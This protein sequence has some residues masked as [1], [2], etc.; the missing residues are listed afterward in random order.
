MGRYRKFES[1]IGSLFRKNLNLNFE[2]VDRDINAQKKRVDDLIKGNPQPSEVVDARLGFP[3]LRE[4]L[5]DTDSRLAQK[6]QQTELEIEKARINNLVAHAGNTGGNAELLDIRV[7]IDGI[8]HSTAGGAVR[9]VGARFNQLDKGL[10]NYKK[11]NVK[12]KTATFSSNRAQ[13]STFTG[14]AWPLFKEDFSGDIFGFKIYVCIG[15][16]VNVPAK[17]AILNTSRAVLQEFNVTIPATGWVQLNGL[18]RLADLPDT[19]FIGITT[20]NGVVLV[21]PNINTITEYNDRGVI[22]WY[23]TNGGNTWVNASSLTSYRS[24]IEV[25][26]APTYDFSLGIEI[27]ELKDLTSDN[28][29]SVLNVDYSPQSYGPELV[30]NPGF[31]SWGASI[32]SWLASAGA[33]TITKETVAPYAGTNAVV[34]THGNNTLWYDTQI[35][36]DI[37]V[38]PGTTYELTFWTK[39][40]GVN[41]GV[42]ALYRNTAPATYLI[43]NGSTGVTGVNW[44][45]VT[46]QFTVPAGC[47]SVKIWFFAPNVNGGFAVFDDVSFKSLQ[48]NNMN[49][50][51]TTLQFILDNFPAKAVKYDNQGTTLEAKNIQDVI[52]ELLELANGTKKSKVALNLPEKYELVVGDTFELFYKGI[53]YA[54]NPYIY[55][56]KVTS[57]KGQAFSKR[58][59]YT[60]VA[61]DV[62]T[63]TLNIS[64][65]DDNDLVLD[66][67]S[68]QLIVKPKATSPST[69]KVV[70]C[71]G[72]SLTTGGI[73]PSE[74]YRRL[75]GTSGNP[76]GDGIANLKTIGT[77]T[78]SN[79]AKYEGYGG[80]TFNQYNTNF[81]STSGAVWVS[82]SSGMKTE[83][84]YQHSVWKDSNGI[85]WKIETIDAE[86]NRLKM[87]KVVSGNQVIPTSGTL[88][89]VSGGGDDTTAIVYT[90]HSYETSNPFW[91]DGKV[92]FAA[93][94]AKHGVARIDYV[95][96]LL[97]WNSTTNTEEAY[98]NAARTFI[99]NVRASFPNAEIIFMGLQV[100]SIDGF[101][102]NYGAS[103]N[104]MEKLRAVFNFDKWYTDLTK[105]YEKMD[106]INIAGQFDTEHNHPT[107]TRAV[108]VRNSLI[109]TYGTNGV[110]PTGEGYRQIADAVYR[111]LTHKITSQ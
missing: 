85:E 77:L 34:L 79:G 62:G 86:N 98:K 38:V 66:S 48:N 42:F 106:F 65:L 63:H 81:N 67:S 30:K 12:L 8:T 54:N 50:I 109:E 93:Y 35:S 83:E 39:G 70:L 43:T 108:N 28:V 55:N 33:G 10:N 27:P 87:L 88:I 92:D 1:L 82:V 22:H 20:T 11:E 60:P 97:G 25:L 5:E 52:S 18:F 110:H 72:D 107:G 94:A 100:P 37:T 31:E 7:G 71:V 103:W 105:E 73:W 44:T 15:T 96:V 78:G 14:W 53:L 32:A 91:I 9:S 76:A 74:M 47:T 59:I 6:A 17:I 57:S 41:A 84:L 3:L 51:Q 40:D 24:L 19:F 13:L 21:P 80:W 36:Q 99:E 101:G 75:T 16:A 111:N 58:Y 26:D 64:V 61:S 104:F 4:K 46:R 95:Y 68:V 23:T 29:E 56:I 2:D 102:A 90:L 45:K 89:W 69:E 49:G